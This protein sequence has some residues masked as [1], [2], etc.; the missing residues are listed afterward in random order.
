MASKIILTIHQ[1]SWFCS[2]QGNFKIIGIGSADR[3]WGDVKI[4]KSGKRSAI[5]SDISE[6]QSIVYK[7]VC[8][9][10]EIIGRNIS[11]IDSKYG[12]HSHSWDDD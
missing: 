5:G 4:I 8:I 2:L 12:S 6:N 3:S 10:E 11:H 1:S 7:S 9:E